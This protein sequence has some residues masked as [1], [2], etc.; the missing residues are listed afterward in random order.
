MMLHARRDQGMHLDLTTHVGERMS[1]LYNFATKVKEIHHNVPLSP[2]AGRAE[3]YKSIRSPTK[4]SGRV[5]HL[6]P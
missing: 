6:T 2:Y 4:I 1:S 5:A 3:P